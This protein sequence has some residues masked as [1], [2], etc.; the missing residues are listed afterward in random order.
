MRRVC[1]IGK[2]SF[3]YNAFNFVEK[4][5]TFSHK[6]I[7][8]INFDKYDK[9]VLLSFPRKYFLKKEKKFLFEKK[10]FKKFKN[11]EIHYISTSKLYPMKIMCSEK[12]KDINLNMPYVYNKFMIENILKKYT[13]KFYI[14]RI[15][16]AFLKN[17]YAKK[18]FFDILVNNWNKN[19][20]IN[21]DINF[22]SQKDFISINT[23]KMIFK[24]M[25]KIEKNFGVY[26]LGAEKGINIQKVIK[27][28]IN[29]NAFEEA[30]LLIEGSKISSQTLDITKLTTLLKLKKKDIIK[31][32]LKEMKKK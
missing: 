8:K 17:K 14:Y 1:L 27:L 6:Q 22:K 24:K 3:L 32:T 18:T 4:H 26:N 9:L 15:S 2:N 31:E 13:R 19:K 23:L 25:L 7:N 11:K 21:F 28:F 16:N 30:N 5:N 20:T 10:L 12:I 29:N